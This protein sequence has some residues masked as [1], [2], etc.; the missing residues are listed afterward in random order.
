MI[1][2]ICGIQKNDMSELIYKTETYS[3]TWKT[4]FFGDKNSETNFPLCD[5]QRGKVG[6]G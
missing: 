3:Q 5:N 6:E 2:I 4:N 1:L